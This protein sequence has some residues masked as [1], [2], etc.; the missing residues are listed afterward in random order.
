[1]DIARLA[2]QYAGRAC[3]LDGRD[4]TVAGRLLPFARV[5][6]LPDGP[7]VEYAWPTVARVFLRTEGRFVS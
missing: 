7:A 1:M 6:A 4:A 5:C 2:D 3:T